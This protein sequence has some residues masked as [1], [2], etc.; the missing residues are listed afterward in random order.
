MSR[1]IIWTLRSWFMF[2]YCTVW[3]EQL[4]CFVSRSAE[5]LSCSPPFCPNS[6]V[7]KCSHIT[8]LFAQFSR[9]PNLPL[10]GL[11]YGGPSISPPVGDM[12]RTPNSSKTEVPVEWKKAKMANPPSIRSGCWVLFGGLPPIQIALTPQ[13]CLVS[14]GNWPFWVQ[15]SEL[16]HL[17]CPVL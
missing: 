14:K 6:P 4:L 10:D 2:P 12:E 9:T 3:C 17:G 7:L 1:A 8:S 15:I 16:P 5:T 13:N 11:G